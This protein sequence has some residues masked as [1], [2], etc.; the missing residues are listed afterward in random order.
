MSTL[1]YS[2]PLPYAVQ[3][4]LFFGSDTKFPFSLD[5]ARENV[6]AAMV[7][8]RQWYWSNLGGYTFKALPT[9]VVTSAL[10]EAQIWAAD[11]HANGRL[12]AAAAAAQDAGLIDPRS[13]RRHYGLVSP[14]PSA[15]GVGSSGT[16]SY[17]P[18]GALH[19]VPGIFTSPGNGAWLLMGARAITT[20]ANSPGTGGATI[21]M[22]AGMG[23]RF[24]NRTAPFPLRVYGP[25]PAEPET[26]GFEI[27]TVTSYSA[28]SFAVDRAQSGT[29]ARNIVAGDQVRL[30]DT[31]A[32]QTT[33]VQA[34]GGHAHEMGHCL[35]GR[36]FNPREMWT[37][38][39]FTQ[40]N[41]VT[42]APASPTTGTQMTIASPPDNV[43]NLPDPPYEAVV[44][45]GNATGFGE[46]ERVRVTARTGTGPWVLTMTRGIAGTSRPIGIGDKIYPLYAHGRRDGQGYWTLLEHSPEVYSGY[47]GGPTLSIMWDWPGYGTAP[48]SILAAERARFLESQQ[49]SGFFR[50]YATMPTGL[51]DGVEGDSPGAP[52]SGY[53]VQ[54]IVWWASDTA[55]D[56]S[57]WPIGLPASSAAVLANVD[58]HIE[59][60]RR[61]FWEQMVVGGEHYTFDA[62]P[63][64]FY[65][66]ALSRAALEVTSPGFQHFDEGL[67]AADSA[68]ADVDVTN[69]QRLYVMVTPLANAAGAPGPGGGAAAGGS[70]YAAN[71]S[72]L[73]SFGVA[74]QLPG[75]AILH[76]VFGAFFQSPWDD[77]SAISIAAA[78]FAHE[79][80]HIFGHGP[81][82]PPSDH[83]YD[84]EAGLPTPNLMSS[85]SGYLES[86]TISPAARAAFADS[87]FL[88][89]HE[90]SP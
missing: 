17:G 78:I 10:T 45:S 28:D 34:I 27:V 21:T 72:Q 55:S 54:P 18:L 23:A 37:P 41:P 51:S 82:Q 81:E 84:H 12:L 67:F 9:L 42:V 86:T 73:P 74:A 36:F 66:S 25:Y 76:G 52:G 59:R 50:P 58:A 75:V 90:V 3:T 56:S 61:M 35:G 24:L 77:F 60:I 83:M 33:I 1:D 63:A 5:Q 7:N 19:V 48:I 8:I 44:W 38:T 31:P 14:V 4:V 20:V 13:P 85:V 40:G 16:S 26:A 64:A 65:Q 62:L 79:L 70:G 43:N 88:T 46:E 2:P 11:P 68:L 30:D 29:V 6:D 57:V 80:G 47:F 89:V 22:A 49:V 53:L 15:S 87:P 71:I 69:P 32:H 39:M